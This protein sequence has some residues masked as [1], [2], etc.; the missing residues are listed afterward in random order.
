[1]T[2]RLDN[3]FVKEFA[4]ILLEVEAVQVN[5]KKPYTWTS[6]KK[7]PVY[8]DNRRLLS[9]PE[10]RQKIKEKL[11]EGVK[12][13]FPAV[14]AIAA[15]AT[16]GIPYGAMIADALQLPFAYVRAQPKAH[17]MKQRV[18]GNLSAGDRV[19]LIEDLVST[20][21]SSLQ[22]AEAL[23]NIGQKVLGIAALFSYNTASQQAAFKQAGLSLYIFCS[24]AD[25]L[26]EAAAKGLL[27]E[28]E[29]EYMAHIFD[30]V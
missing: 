25:L 26:P 22:A 11:Q 7:F 16:A 10:A 19:V 27:N 13:H 1:M 9:H 17:G 28:E 21:A 18:E 8:C 3:A 12:K 4:H 14:N 5:V 23:R 29:Q 24:Y 30:N 6:G 20:G 2:S 15:V